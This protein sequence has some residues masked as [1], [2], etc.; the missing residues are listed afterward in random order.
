MRS[1]YRPVVDNVGWE[2]NPQDDH[3]RCLLRTLV[4]NAA[5]QLDDEK[6]LAHGL[7]RF[8]SL[9]QGWML[10]PD[11]RAP[12]YN[13]AVHIGVASWY[14]KIKAMHQQADLQEE[15][16]RCLDALACST[17]P[18]RLQQILEF[19][20]SSDVR[21]QDAVYGVMAVAVNPYGRDLAWRFL[22]DRW[23]E[24]DQHYGRGHFLMGLLIRSCT[25]YF[26]TEERAREVEAFFD[27]HP[28]PAAKRAI[29][30]TLEHIRSN[31]A[32]LARDSDAIEQWFKSGFFYC[33]IVKQQQQQ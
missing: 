29:Q 7:H 18:E 21:M 9:L 2:V 1:F 20:L 28:A 22:Q 13:I 12:V 3:R 19:S 33:N 26:T 30:L 32:W 6:T 15:R 27:A 25:Q 14:D 17:D 8:R 24:F 23:Q 16:R 5:G 10:H 31:A 11:L 4:L